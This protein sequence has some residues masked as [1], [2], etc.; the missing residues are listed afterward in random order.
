MKNT[1]LKSQ[2]NQIPT[3]RIEQ[4]FSIRQI[5][6][7]S[8]SPDGK[9]IAYITN[10]NGLPNIWTISI[11]S[12]WTSQIT[13][14]ENAVRGLKYSPK[15]NT[16]IY[17]SDINGDENQ[18]IFL[19][20]DT[21]FN[22]RHLSESH[23][24]SQVFFVKWNKK[25]T[26]ILFT[27][28]KRNR[29]YF[30]T[31]VYDIKNNSE[32]CVYESKSING[33]FPN[34]WSKDERYII[35]NR[36]YDNSNQDV[37]LYDTKESKM[38]NISEHKG[39]MKNLEGRF[40]PDDKV[41]YFLSDY[42]QEFTGL[43]YYKI[44]TGEIGWYVCEK[45]DITHFEF[46]PHGKYLLYNINENGNSK[47]KLKKFTKKDTV[48]LKTKKGNC[49]GFDFTPDEKKIV[50]LFDEPDN[51][52]DIFVYDI[53][54]KKYN[55]VT[56]SL[57]GGISRNILNSAIT[58]KYK[59]FDGLEISANLYIPKGVK[60]DGTNPAIVWPHGGPEWQ[61][62]NNF[63][64][65]FQILTN[66]G[67]IV[68][69][70]NFRGSTGFG[71]TFQKKIYGDWGGAEFKDVLGSYDYLL[72]SGYVDKSKIAVVGGS[73]GGFMTLTCITKAPEL[74]RCAVDI[75]GPSNLFTFLNS[76]PEYWKPAT[77]ELVGDPE[78][79]KD[80]L[81]DRSPINFV[82]K[83]QCPLF[84]IQGKND[85][86]VVQA[87]SDQIVEKLKANNKEVEYLVLHDEGHGFTK[88]QNQILVWNNIIS[89]LD[90]QLK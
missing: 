40:S 43:A 82:D 46:S 89:F 88:V 7:L 75:F 49:L 41:V 29:A 14:E 76:I 51:P 56:F 47:L 86:R 13:I 23:K 28:N 90:K 2:N 36:F 31:Y 24:G 62:K 69:A 19:I 85:P 59:S 30:D 70:P 22:N 33:E 57:T 72:N 84:I 54:S 63:N 4:F 71:K 42:E 60:K 45:W 32:K 35:F 50:M 78:K 20:D 16:L 1:E 52:N 44:K 73:F 18:Q 58:V 9:T 74:W 15:K 38:T 5:I 3:L 21:G 68:I 66:R 11:N 81:Q 83:I 53:K 77:Y 80:L 17:Q 64:K 37:L 34:D 55:Q 10:T 25:G 87:E 79:D 39:N 6:D 67:Y 8:I 61:E 12:G 48:N 26:K 27:S 65:Y